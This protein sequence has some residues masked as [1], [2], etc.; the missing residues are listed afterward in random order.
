[1]LQI[2]N[3]LTRRKETFEPMEPGNVRIYVC[4]M[5]VY[6]YCHLGHARAMVVFDTVVRHLRRLGFDVRYVRNIT[7]VDDK[8]IRRA[9]E[10][11]ES[12]EALTARF[13]AAMHEDA[14]AL[15]CLRPDREPRAT[16]HMDAIIAMIERLLERGYAYVADNGDVYYAVERFPEYGKLS[17]ERLEDLRAGAR[18]EPGEAKRDPADFALW[19]A[20]QPGE[21]SWVSPWGQGRP[22]WHIECSAMSTEALGPHFDIHGGG[23]DLKFP[24]HENEIAQSEAACGE[25]FVNYWMHNG[26]VR[27]DDEKMSKSLGNF[28]TVRDI[29]AEHPPEVVRHFLLTSHYRSPLNY[30]GESLEA[31]AA[32][33]ERLYRSLRGLPDAE[34]V[35][36]E[37]WRAR[38]DAAMNDDFNTPEALAVLFELARVVNRAREAG[39]RDA[40]GLGA[41]LRELGADLGL[42]RDDPEAFL[43]GSPAGGPD[44]AEVERLIA[45]R[46]E[47]RR[48]REFARADAIREQ[49]Q[50][51]GVVIEDSPEGTTWRRAR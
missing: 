32:A 34:P 4:G 23:L 45:E 14:D 44:D 15:G 30:T 49:L 33:L 1:M 6:D 43:K 24:H 28:F 8:I 31:S 7:D 29:L 3:S 42:L 16:A 46:A 35:D 9:A 36:P 37:D 13:T 10:S 27:I 19:K 12:P 47:A 2:Y 22:G 25:T 50:S 18:I 21:P 11:G 26:H 20:A 48:N 5:T 17:G 41:L 51:Q 40:A 38:F 39:E